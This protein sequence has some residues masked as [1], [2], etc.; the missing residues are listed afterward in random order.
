M[1]FISNL[2]PVLFFRLMKLR[3]RDTFG[4]SLLLS[5]PLSLMVV[6]ASLGAKMDFLTSELKGVL[7][8][9]AVVSSIVYPSLF[10]HVAKKIGNNVPEKMNKIISNSLV[11]SRSSAVK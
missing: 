7:I 6:A 1:V 9:T 10:R 2:F 4:M 11:K 8:L 3:F 5:S